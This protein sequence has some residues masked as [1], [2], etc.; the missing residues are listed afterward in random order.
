MTQP[1]SRG[2]WSIQR[3]E[4]EFCFI[5][6]ILGSLHFDNDQER[7]HT[8]GEKLALFLVPTVRAI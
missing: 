1:L 8:K 3:D 2:R 4:M 5:T 7:K 6:E